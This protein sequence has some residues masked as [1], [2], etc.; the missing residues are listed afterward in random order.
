MVH[1][2][3]RCADMSIHICH[4]KACQENLVTKLD[5]VCVFETFDDLSV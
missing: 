4:W 2:N 1:V 3:P 5:F